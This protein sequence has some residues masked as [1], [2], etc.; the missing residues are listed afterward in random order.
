VV[1]RKVLKDVLQSVR[2]VRLG[3][4]VF[5]IRKDGSS[6]VTGEGGALLRG[7]NPGCNMLGS[8]SNFDSN[9]TAIK[10][11]LNGPFFNING[12][13][14]SFE[15]YT[16]LA[17]T[18]LNVGQLYSN[19]NNPWFGGTFD[20]AGFDDATPTSNGKSV[21]FSCQAS[22]ALIITDGI[23]TRDGKI[24]GTAFAANPMTTAVAN[25]AGALAGMDG[26]NI[27]GIS[28][29]DCPV[30]N[31]AA[32]AADTSVAAGT[33]IG[34]QASGAC[35]DGNN[36]IPSYLP[37]VAWYLNNLDLRP[38]TEEGADKPL[39]LKGKQVV[40][41]YTIG[42]GTSG[43]TSEILRHTAQAGG[44]LFNGG[45]GTDVTDARS[46]KDA[47]M[48]ALEDVNSR[49]T[50]FGAASLSTLQ[51]ASSQGVLIPRFEPSRNA[52]W[53]GHLY[54]FDLYSEFAGGCSPQDP[55][56]SGPPNKDYDCYGK[57]SSV[58]L[59]DA[60]G[61]FIQEDGTGAFKKNLDRTK[62]QCG[63]GS[64]CPASRCSGPDPAA[65]AK[66]YWDAGSK[67]AP[68]TTTIDPVSKLAIESANPDFKLEWWQRKIYTVVDD[69][70]DGKF[71]LADPVIDLSTASPA[72]LVPYLNIKGTRYCQALASRLASLQAEDGAKI[73]MELSP[74]VL[75]ATTLAA[76]VPTTPKSVEYTTC[77]AVLLKFVRGADVFKE[78]SCAGYP[79]RS[80]PGGTYCTRKYQLGD[81]FHS[82]PIEVWPPLPSDGFSCPRG[83]HPQCLQ[84]LFSSAIKNPSTATP[85]NANAYDDYAKSDRY[86]NRKKFVLVGAN[87]GMLHAI[88][89]ERSDPKAGE[90]IW[91]FVPPDLLP[92][93]RMLTEN[94]HQFYVDATPM[95]RDV[96]LDDIEN[97]NATLA[98]AAADGVRQGSEF[99]TVA[100][101]GERRG[102][103]RYFALDVTEV[104]AQGETDY[105]PRFLWLYPQPTDPASLAMG[106]TYVEFVP[107][108]PPIGPV[109]IDR[110]AAPCPGELQVDPD[111]SGRCFEER[112]IVFL[113]GG[114]DPQFTKGRGVYMVDL[115]TGEALW[116]FAQTPGPASG[117]DATK[118]PRC[119]LHYPVASTVGMMMWGNQPA[120]LS[121]A[122]VNGYFDTATFGDTGGQLWVL[123]FNVP[124]R[125][126]GI[127]SGKVTNWVGA[128]AL[129]HGGATAH[130]CGL[131][132][133]DSQPFFYIS[134][135]VPLA[136][137]G[138]YRTLAG[139]GDRFNVLDPVGG[140]CGPDNIRACLLKGCTV[141]IGD[142][143]GGPGAVYGVEPLLGKQSYSAQHPAT[144]TGLDPSTHRLDV[145][146]PGAA[147][148]TTL[149]SRVD[150]ITITCPKANT[151]SG[152]VETT[153][154][155]AGVVCTS[156]ACSP[157]ASNEYGIP[158]DLKGNPD[159]R[160]WF[161]SVLVFERTGARTVFNTPDEAKAYDAARLDESDLKNVNAADTSPVPANL[162][163]PEGLGWSYFFN[164]GSSTTAASTTQIAGVDHNVYRTDERTA[165]VSAVEYGCVFWNTLQTGVPTGAYDPVSAC[166]INSPCKAG[167]AQISYLYGANAGTGGLCLKVGGTDQRAQKNETLVPPH[168]GK[169]VA[170]VGEG[171]VS[172][173][174]TSVRVPAGGANVQLGDV[175]DIAAT[176]QWLP[177]DREGH[178][179]RHA[180]KESTPGYTAPPTSAVCKP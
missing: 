152:E 142:A 128:R 102:G 69:S 143:A 172:F 177:V 122:A 60:D 57:C 97:G 63:N 107:K 99:H 153:R 93:L 100:V 58:F 161:F 14:Y 145:T 41:T 113:S 2:K 150:G 62:A 64:S 157:D 17:E 51:I 106:E 146:A 86:K 178:D 149:T 32:E 6:I 119:F 115:A 68:V 36:P 125:R 164:H 132:Y 85:P 175:Q 133:C 156:D 33:C 159:K 7:L 121:A 160:N 49:S 83:L 29:T 129:Q 3:L 53:D 28:S 50:S 9:R 34:Q 19:V 114:F 151:C 89:I 139:T 138:L 1:A 23:P 80:N 72:A 101:V 42:L 140:Q 131:G 110:G 20:Q 8:P 137:N 44:G 26:Y 163:S 39:L 81:I 180:P 174:L 124:G 96:W 11:L 162:A 82:S 87:D 13:P 38:D 155:G 25:Q 167:R 47:I 66:P 31:T 37:K 77:A 45:S 35:D 21:C 40:S 91:G 95:V 173:G 56:T 108:P 30:C 22:A 136:A 171:Q 5:N 55:A 168:I 59:M 73:T 111:G 123:R 90:E 52:H 134:S 158:I 127:T 4:T 92:K 48:R 75:D 79:T 116:E 76:V 61:H 46:L 71:T 84:S 88:R 109:K 176:T 65:P 74:V 104:L 117:C 166:P 43:N 78:R 144:C 15:G 103:T 27:T 16:P 24:P 141:T 18:L 147:A 98:S 105:K 154:K 179:C 112:W 126:S 148:C 54:S 10:N 169:L 135:N 170:Y 118:D 120:F 67:L 130:A 94:V 165:S 70:G 12:N